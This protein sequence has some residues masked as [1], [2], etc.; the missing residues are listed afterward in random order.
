[1]VIRHIDHICS[2]GGEHH[3]GFGSDFDGMDKTIPRLS[4]Y[5]DYE[6]LIESLLKYYSAR[7]VKSFL[8]DNFVRRFPQ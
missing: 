5:K 1:D 3:L 4:R 8:F 2:L 7:Q 6:I